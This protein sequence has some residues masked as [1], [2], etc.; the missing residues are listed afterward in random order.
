MNVC[1]YKLA[2][3]FIDTECGLFCGRQNHCAVFKSHAFNLRRRNIRT[4]S[5]QTHSAC[6]TNIYSVHNKYSPPW[7]FNSN[8]NQGNGFLDKTNDKKTKS[9]LLQRNAN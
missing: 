7:K 1:V 6:S 8:H 9:S 2:C 5:E 4:V 3:L